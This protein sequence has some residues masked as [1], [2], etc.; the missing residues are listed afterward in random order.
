M[1]TIALLLFIKSIRISKLKSITYLFCE[2]V[3]ER[4]RER[5]ELISDIEFDWSRVFTRGRYLLEI[6]RY[7]YVFSP[8]LSNF[9]VG[10]NNHC[11][12]RRPWRRTKQ[13]ST[14]LLPAIVYFFSLSL[15]VS[16]RSS[17]TDV[18]GKRRQTDIS[19]K[20]RERKKKK[21]F[22]LNGSNSRVMFDSFP[23]Q[24]TVFLFDNAFG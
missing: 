22:F 24:S 8:Y 9:F 19:E 2:W 14:P 23:H 10:N 13:K 20:K 6:D 18:E 15:C 12:Y 21:C 16:L 3:R 1:S 5:I 4:E 11:R 7:A 17:F